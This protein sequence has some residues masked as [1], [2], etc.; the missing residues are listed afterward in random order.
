MSR[1]RRPRL[2]TPPD[3]QRVATHQVAVESALHLH[4][5]LRNPDYAAAFR[6]RS[7]AE[8]AALRDAALEEQGAGASL[9]LLAAIE[10]AFRVD[11][12]ERDRVRPRDSLSRAM[13]RLFRKKGRFAHRTGDIPK[14]WRDHSN[15]PNPLLN[16]VREAFALRHRLAHGRYDPR[17]LGR[18][19]DD[20]TILDLARAV[21]GSFPFLRV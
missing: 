7:P 3:I 20:A 19:Y 2:R 18:A 21:D 10:A 8:V 5:S 17:R 9:S 14:V 16:G 4:D 12:I 1:Q 13:R 6:F 15:V 11:D